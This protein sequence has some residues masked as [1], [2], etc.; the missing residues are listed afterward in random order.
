MKKLV[1]ILAVLLLAGC[2]GKDQ[3]VPEETAAPLRDYYD[4]MIRNELRE[5]IKGNLDQLSRDFLEGKIS[6]VEYYNIIRSD[7]APKRV[8]TSVD[9]WDYAPFQHPQV[10]ESKLTVLNEQAALQFAAG[11]DFP[12]LDGATAF[13]PLYAA[14]AH[15]AYPHDVIRTIGTGGDPGGYYPVSLPF[16]PDEVKEIDLALAGESSY[17]SQL[18]RNPD[19]VINA[20]IVVQCSR[21]ER[22]YMNLIGSNPQYFYYKEWGRITRPTPMPA[23]TGGGGFNRRLSADEVFLVLSWRPDIIF[24]YEPSAEEKEEAAEK[25]ITLKM[26][27]LGYDAFVFFVN[28]EN[29][30]NNLTQQQVRD[31]YSGKITNWKSI[32]GIDAEIIPYQ[33]PQNSGS[34]TILE[35]IMGDTPIMTAPTDLQPTMAS[36]VEAV[37]D[38]ANHENAIGYSFRFFT[39]SMVDNGEIKILAI[40]GVYPAIETIQNKT[41]PFSQPFY[42]VT[43]GNEKPNT[44]RFIE[45]ML[46]PQGQYLVEKSGYIPVR[47]VR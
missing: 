26:T 22:A 18:F 43:A 31:I 20:G 19:I 6:R 15:A 25:G 13:Y 24:C 34:Q 8:D 29:P 9:L 28:K 42:A 27:P 44:Q 10:K 45:W 35:K 32:T 7:E 41:Y 40:D 16:E 36:M 1:I 4:E 23:A 12:K 11:D 37:A 21:T 17:D 46:S 3:A 5:T 38:Y 33:R 30:V 47:P 14:F 39:A 2:K